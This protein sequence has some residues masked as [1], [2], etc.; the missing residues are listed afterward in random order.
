MPD[1]SRKGLDVDLEVEEKV[2]EASGTALLPDSVR[3]AMPGQLKL[4]I[5]KPGMQDIL[6]LTRSMGVGRCQ[7]CEQSEPT[8]IIIM[9]QA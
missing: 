2:E 5:L 1:E 6:N 8:T 4:D 9:C 3:P 7:H